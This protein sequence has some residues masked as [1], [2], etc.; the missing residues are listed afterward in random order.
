MSSFVVLCILLGIGHLLRSRIRLFQKLYLPSC[1]IGGLAGLLII[2]IL[3]AGSGGCTA[4]ESVS[5]WLDG[6][7]EP[8]RKLPSML[9]NVVFACLFLGV[10]LPSFSDI[11]KRSGPQVVYGQIVAWGQYVVGLGLWVLVLG[12]IFTDLPSMFAGIL[13]VGFEGGHGTAAGMGPVFEKFGWPEGQDLA[14]TSATFGIVSAIVVGMTLVNWAV[15][16]GYAV[17]H[18]ELAQQIEDDSIAVIPVDQRPI[19]GRLT[20][21]SDIIESFSLHLVA[22]GLACGIGMLIKEG[23][24]LIE[25]QSPYLSDNRLLSSFP[26]FP[27]CMI[28]GLV[29]QFL[30]EKY[31]RRKLIDLGLIRRIQNCSLDFLVI[32]AI[33]MIRIDVVKTALVPLLI[34]VAA[35]IA[36]NVF[37]V[38]VL[39]R[40]ILPDAWFERAIAEMGQSMGVTA[41]G[42]LLLRVVDPDYD[43][44]AAD[45]FACKQIVHEPFMGGGLWTSAAIPLIAIYGPSRVLIIALIAVSIWL[46]I[47][48]MMRTKK[49][50]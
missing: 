39:A 21:N 44:P 40:R 34:L 7:T 18:K 46:T 23:L 4:C 12:W 43:T 2:Q 27:L 9:I 41:T 6:V 47:G 25:A 45:A 26:L 20:V 15:R 49:P 37:C 10:K 11:W 8:W 29:I 13:P 24:V 19:A 35:G 38:M 31:D 30:D 16:K 3:S 1:V 50:V 28:G 36:W 22:V 33:A 48:W 5:G 17:R 42:L 32:A 14:M